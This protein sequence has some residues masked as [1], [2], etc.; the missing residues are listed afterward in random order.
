MVTKLF[1]ACLLSFMGFVTRST[2]AIAKTQR[3]AVYVILEKKG[4]FPGVLFGLNADCAISQVLLSILLKQILFMFTRRTISHCL[5]SLHSHKTAHLISVYT[6]IN[7][8]FRSSL[9][10]PRLKMG[11]AF[12]KHRGE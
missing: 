6:Y 11:F 10:N 4:G 2:L 7:H 3:R 12:G 9:G 1:T 5:L 8:I